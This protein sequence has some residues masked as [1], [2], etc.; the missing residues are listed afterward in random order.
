[1]Y[2]K[3]KISESFR[4]PR[5][6]EAILEVAEAKFLVSS[7]F[8][9][10]SFEIFVVWVLGPLITVTSA[11]SKGAQGFFFK[12]YIFEISAFQPQYTN[13]KKKK[14]RYA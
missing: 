9:E 14:M 6:Q 1:M 2:L 10:F 11:T 4:G 12:S 3:K 13:T 8:N 5:G 7:I